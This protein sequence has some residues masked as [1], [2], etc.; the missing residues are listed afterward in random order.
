MS[1]KAANKNL[2]K[3][4]FTFVL[5]N[6]AGLISLFFVYGIFILFLGL[7]SKEDGGSLEWM[8]Q[9]A[10]VVIGDFIIFIGS[11][12]FLRWFLRKY[13]PKKKTLKITL[14]MLYFLTFALLIFLF[15]SLLFPSAVGYYFSSII[16]SV[17]F[18]PL[19]ISF[20]LLFRSIKG[21]RLVAHNDKNS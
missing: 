9:T 16:I 20:L 19:F 3:R 6:I 2:K 5:L 18:V 13:A 17:T 11:F 8:Y 1:D 10:L 12:Y 4:A 21:L 7:L 15:L 14:P